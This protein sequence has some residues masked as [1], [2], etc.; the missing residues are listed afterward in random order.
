MLHNSCHVFGVGLLS[1]L[2]IDNSTRADM[3]SGRP[4]SVLS[5][6]RQCVAAPHEVYP[7]RMCLCASISFA[8]LTPVSQWLSRLLLLWYVLD[9]F[10]LAGSDRCAQI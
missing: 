4:R 2:E 8:E 3:D 9:A 6:L 10:L 7:T 1:L 5:L